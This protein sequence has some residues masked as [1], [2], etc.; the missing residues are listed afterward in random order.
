MEKVRYGFRLWW[1][2]CAKFLRRIDMGEVGSFSKE[3][4]HGGVMFALPDEFSLDK[5]QAA[6]ILYDCYKT[7]MF[8]LPMMKAIRKS[9]AYAYELKG[10]APLSNFPKVKSNWKVIRP[11]ELPGI[12]MSQKPERIPTPQEL[13]VCFNKEWTTAHPWPL[14][15]FLGG[16][17]AAND[18]YLFG[19]RSREDTS[20]VKFS[21]TH[22][23][24][25]KKGWQC[26]EFVGGRA[27]LCGTKKGSRTWHIW[28]VCFC[29]KKK[30]IRPPETFCELI[31]DAGN[32]TTTGKVPFY[33]LCPLA[34]LELMWQLQPHH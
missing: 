6:R 31:D 18:L 33:T 2:G 23:F 16:L 4:Q 21:V 28:R 12:T 14:L 20:R 17:V 10:G 19:L 1:K 26:T 11:T 29:R 5:D 30:H 25:W 27:K 3:N 8:T 22:E 32:P 24:N 15:D 9:L 13:K 7:R 34:A